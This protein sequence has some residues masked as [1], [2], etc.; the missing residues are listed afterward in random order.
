LTAADGHAPC[1]RDQI[2]AAQ[3]QYYASIGQKVNYPPAH[4]LSDSQLLTKSGQI[5][6][7]DHDPDLSLVRLKWHDCLDPHPTGYL[8]TP[9]RLLSGRF[10]WCTITLQIQHQSHLILADSHF[11]GDFGDGFFLAGKLENPL[12]FFFFG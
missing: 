7:S 3:A 5:S 10:D 6:S 12:D 9:M 4:N 2:A 8:E 1:L 11:L